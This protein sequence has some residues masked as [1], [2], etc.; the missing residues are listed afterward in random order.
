MAFVA[1]DVVYRLTTGSAGAA[2]NASA[3]TPA[4]SLGKFV[5]TTT[6]SAGGPFDDISDGE[7]RGS[8]TD[9]RCIA[10]VNTHPTDT[11]TNAKV[12]VISQV[13]GG[14]TVTLAIDPTPASAIGSATAQAQVIATE[15]TAPAGIASWAA[16]TGDSTGLLLGDLPAGYCRM[17]WIKRTAADTPALTGDGYSFRVTGDQV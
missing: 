3:G 6:V 8:V 7:N 4:A 10:V 12:W 11:I 14:A 15:T 9:Y 17:V 5:S 1:S 13:T 2:G 16:P